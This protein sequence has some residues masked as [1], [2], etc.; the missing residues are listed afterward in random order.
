MKDII[1]S[2]IAGTAIAAVLIS[3]E[4][5]KSVVQYLAMWQCWLLLI[6]INLIRVSYKLKRY[7]R[8]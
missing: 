7:K 5:N 6:G 3:L 8:K 1:V 2:M 4:P